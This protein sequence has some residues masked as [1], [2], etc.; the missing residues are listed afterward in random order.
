MEK[1]QNAPNIIHLPKTNPT[2]LIYPR[3]TCDSEFSQKLCRERTEFL[4][5][6]W[7]MTGLQ[8]MKTLVSVA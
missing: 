8:V 1:F 4:P 2:A 5:V 7:Y 3:V 6:C